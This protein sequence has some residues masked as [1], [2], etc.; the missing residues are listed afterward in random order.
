[1]SPLA[2]AI[3]VFWSKGSTQATSTDDAEGDAI[4]PANACRHVRRQ[5]ESLYIE[6][7]ERYQVER[8]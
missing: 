5:T 3:A 2:R 4:R 6:A 1:M 7:M 8:V